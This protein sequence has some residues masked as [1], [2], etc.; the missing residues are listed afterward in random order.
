MFCSPSTIRSL[1]SVSLIA[2]VFSKPPL[3]SVFE[4]L[5]VPTL[6]PAV[7]LGAIFDLRDF[8]KGTFWTQHI[9]SQAKLL[10]FI[11]AQNITK[12]S[13]NNEI[14]DLPIIS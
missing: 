2:H 7:A 13:K 12:S 10:D 6:P 5:L 1:I 8:Q 3:G 11:H 14:D 9:N 4:G